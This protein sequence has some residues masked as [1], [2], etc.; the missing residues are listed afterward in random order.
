MYSEN[1]MFYSSNIFL[2]LWSVLIN[3]TFKTQN[4]YTHFQL[5][6]VNGGEPA[7]NYQ[8]WKQEDVS[9]NVKQVRASSRLM[10]TLWSLDVQYEPCISMA[11]TQIST[12]KKSC[13]VK[14]HWEFQRAEGTTWQSWEKS[15]MSKVKRK[16]FVSTQP[17][18]GS[19]YW[20]DSHSSVTLQV[21]LTGRALGKSHRP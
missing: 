7:E 1:V 19:L 5:F 11:E 18:P 4:T 12:E 9:E 13:C 2:N 21:S 8:W 6:S 20:K 15:T 10:G 14:Y 16:T 17:S 3:C